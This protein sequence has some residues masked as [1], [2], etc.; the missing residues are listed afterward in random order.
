MLVD[1]ETDLRV[2]DQQLPPDVCSGAS[3]GAWA[4][5]EVRQRKPQL[6]LLT[7]DSDAP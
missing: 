2:Y 5:L 6:L 7:Q 1:E 3:C 4:W